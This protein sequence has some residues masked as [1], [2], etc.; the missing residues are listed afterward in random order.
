MT[1][2]PDLIIDRN[3]LKRKILLWKIV[4]FIAILIL[5]MVYFNKK[6]VAIN[7]DGFVARV[8]IEDEIFE[9][10]KQERI[11]RNLASNKAVKAVIIHINSPGGTEVGSENLFFAIREIANNKPV[12]ATLGTVAASGGYMVALAADQIFARSS[13][14]TGSIGLIMQFPEYTDLA[15]K[16]GIKFTTIKSAELK[17]VPSPYEPLSI[18][19]KEVTQE[20]IMDNFYHFVNM[21]AERRNISKDQALKLAD[22]RV[23]SGNQ[24]QKLKLIDALGG[25]EEAKLWLEKNK[26][27]S[28]KLPVK[29]IE[30]HIKPSPFEEF[31]LSMAKGFNLK[32]ALRYIGSQTDLSINAR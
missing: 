5:G 12:V 4:F 27:I 28:S 14:I 19:A 30:I 11:L 16:L 3:N 17:A 31:F 24:A 13:T 8:A 22:G 15:E 9:D 2:T 26:S 25:E 6:D 20:L 1:L 32:S 29:D 18:K 21:V 7:P 10:I 23:Y